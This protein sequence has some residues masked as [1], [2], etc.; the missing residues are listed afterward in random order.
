VSVAILDV[1]FHLAGCRSLKEK[2]QRLNGLRE[3]YGRT[4]NVAV[5]ESEYQDLLQRARWSFVAAAADRS[6][7]ARVLTEIEHNL[8]QLVDAEV[9]RV[10]RRWLA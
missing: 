7:V 2:R 9:V 8:E 5:S 3:R 1:E 10:Q 4:Y 6:A